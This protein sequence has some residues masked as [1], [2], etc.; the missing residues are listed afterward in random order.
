MVALVNRKRFIYNL[1][2]VLGYLMRCVC[3]KDLKRGRHKRSIRKHFFFDKCQE[4]MN[5]ELDVVA[6]LK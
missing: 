3:C 1:G 5:Q 4:N 6:L 2:D